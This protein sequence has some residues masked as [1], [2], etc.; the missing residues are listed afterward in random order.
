MKPANAVS[1][2]LGFGIGLALTN[3]MYQTMKPYGKT[4]KPI[5]ICL[6]CQGRNALEN[7]FCWHC[8]SAIYPQSRT[9]CT[10]CKTTVP[11][12]N[13]CGN[14]GSKLKK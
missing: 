13:Y 7:E 6:K 3:Y 10:K 11:S 14:C 5:I 1:T 2:G 12:M 9:Q 4:A 8:G